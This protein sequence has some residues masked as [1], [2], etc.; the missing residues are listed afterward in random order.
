MKADATLHEVIESEIASKLRVWPSHH[1]FDHALR[2]AAMTTGGRRAGPPVPAAAVNRTSDEV[3]TDAA[4]VAELAASMPTADG[5]R[6][7]VRDQFATMRFLESLGRG[8]GQWR[9]TERNMVLD[10]PGEKLVPSS[11]SSAHVEVVPAGEI[12]LRISVY[13][14]EKRGKIEQ[15]FFVLSSQPLSVLKDRIYCLSDHVL[16]GTPALCLSV[17]FVDNPAH[18]NCFPMCRLI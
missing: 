16:D 9:G 8:R 7:S 13:H 14:R 1:V 6:T 3:E 5:L 2:R 11:S 10:E 15:E 18:I 12:V 4:A 17:C